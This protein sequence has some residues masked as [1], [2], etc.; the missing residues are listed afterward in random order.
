[1][2]I[3]K[4]LLLIGPSGITFYSAGITSINYI[5]IFLIISGLIY[6]AILFFVIHI[7]N[8]E[9]AGKYVPFKWSKD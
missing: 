1:M 7:Y 3:S 4:S 8:S 2:E 6:P 9:G 5:G